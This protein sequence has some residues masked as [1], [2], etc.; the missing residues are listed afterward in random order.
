MTMNAKETLSVQLERLRA[1]MAMIE[2]TPAGQ[3]HD[4]L[5]ERARVA[6]A[7]VRESRDAA[8]RNGLRAR[9]VDATHGCASDYVS[10]SK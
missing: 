6:I 9:S 1:I 2:V 3:R 7:A 8:A 5:M 4:A 10:A